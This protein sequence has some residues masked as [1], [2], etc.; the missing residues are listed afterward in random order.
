[1]NKILNATNGL[2]VISN[3]YKDHLMMVGVI[4]VALHAGSYFFGN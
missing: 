1:M 3:L 2:A 4:I